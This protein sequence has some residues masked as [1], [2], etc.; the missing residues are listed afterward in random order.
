[1]VLELLE[2]L[3]ATATAAIEATARENFIVDGW[4]ERRTNEVRLKEEKEKAD[5]SLFL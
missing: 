2:E 3:A 5:L 4:R 1:V